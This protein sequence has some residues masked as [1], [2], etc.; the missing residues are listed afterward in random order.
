MHRC[1]EVGFEARGP[2]F[3]CDAFTL[4]ANEL[5]R[6]FVAEPLMEV[7]KARDHLSLM[8][9]EPSI[10]DRTGNLVRECGEQAFVRRV[11]VP[12]LLATPIIPITVVPTRRGTPRNVSTGG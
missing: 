8:L 10:V 7:L 4:M 12:A 6:L 9:V 3:G 1:V 11:V 2:S 5:V